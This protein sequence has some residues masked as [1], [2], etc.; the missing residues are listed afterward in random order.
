MSSYMVLISGTGRGGI[1][2]LAEL[3]RKIS[4]FKFAKNIKDRSFK[5]FKSIYLKVG[6]EKF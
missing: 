2:L 4:N 5:K 3:V 6:L 1:N